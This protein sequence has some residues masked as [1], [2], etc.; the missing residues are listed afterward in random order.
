MTKIYVYY[1]FDSY[2]FAHL[3]KCAF[4]NVP[5]RWKRPPSLAPQSGAERAVIYTSEDLRNAVPLAKSRLVRGK[6][7]AKPFGRDFKS[8]L[9]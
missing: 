8:S 6:P 3:L 5:L 9:L 2:T 4:G 7:L 1:I